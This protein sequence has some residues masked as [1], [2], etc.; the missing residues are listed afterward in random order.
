[1]S[2][3][4]PADRLNSCAAKLAFI[5]DAFTQEKTTR[6]SFSEDGMYGFYLIVRDI[7]LEIRKI[8]EEV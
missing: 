2:T 1:M 7:E 4:H 6:F 5:Q 3:E 8:M